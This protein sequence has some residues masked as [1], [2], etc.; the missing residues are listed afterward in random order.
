MG[1]LRET[2]FSGRGPQRCEVFPGQPLAVPSIPVHT[3]DFVVRSGMPEHYSVIEI[4][5]VLAL[6]ASC[7][8]TIPFLTGRASTAPYVQYTVHRTVFERRP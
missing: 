7:L 2:D 6:R 4:R 1:S 5:E 8:P 3:P